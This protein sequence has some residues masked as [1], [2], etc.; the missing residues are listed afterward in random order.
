MDDLK[1]N[2]KLNNKLVVKQAF[3]K[4]NS[5]LLYLIS[6]LSKKNVETYIYI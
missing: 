2:T 4:P 1:R 3:K 6:Y 5:L